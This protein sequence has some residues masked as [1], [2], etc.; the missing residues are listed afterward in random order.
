MSNRKNYCDTG[1]ENLFK[2]CRPELGDEGSTFL[3]NPYNNFHHTII[4]SGKEVKMITRTF[5]V[6]DGTTL[7]FEPSRNKMEDIFTVFLQKQES[8]E[9]TTWCDGQWNQVTISN[10][11]RLLNPLQCGIYSPYNL[12]F[13]GVDVRADNE[14]RTGKMLD[15]K[16]NS[17]GLEVTIE[18]KDVEKE[19]NATLLAH[20]EGTPEAASAGYSTTT[21]ILNGMGLSLIHICRCRRRG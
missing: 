12:F 11:S 2:E 9:A 15:Q 3:V 17:A 10:G 13:R 16:I 8:I 1:I 5:Q 4:Q 19:V 21:Y 18:S 14:E 7:V 20:N 6:Y